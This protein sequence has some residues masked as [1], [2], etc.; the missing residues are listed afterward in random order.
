MAC[1]IGP[2]RRSVEM[3]KRPYHRAYEDCH[4]E[5]GS[6]SR[7]KKLRGDSVPVHS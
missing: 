6:F 5:I 2:Q 7:R 3:I 4:V 1:A